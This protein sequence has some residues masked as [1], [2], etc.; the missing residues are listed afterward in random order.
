MRIVLVT[1]VFD[2]LHIEHIR[3][4]TKAKALGDKLLVGIESDYRVKEI[5]GYERPV[6]NQEVRKEQ[7]E[8]LKPVDEVLFLPDNFNS[9]SDWESL[10]ARIKPYAYAVSSHSSFLENKRWVCKKY[11]VRFEVVHKF[12]PDYSSSKILQKLTQEIG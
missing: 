8:A 6:N 12:N 9:Q 1:G 3:F 2:L 10:I 7:L 5:K 4:L 11:G